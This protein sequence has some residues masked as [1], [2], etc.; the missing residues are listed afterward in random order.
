MHMN[1]I[2]IIEDGKVKKFATIHH[3]DIP[4]MVINSITN[5]AYC[6]EHTCGFAQNKLLDDRMSRHD[7]YMRVMA[8]AS[9]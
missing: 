3:Y 9:E 7:D 1:R 2:M 4:A 6:K 5:G 8:H